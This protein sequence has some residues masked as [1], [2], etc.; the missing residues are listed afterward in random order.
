LTLDLKYTIKDI[1]TQSVN[2]NTHKVI[3]EGNLVVQSYGYMPLPHKL[4]A[5]FFN[6][7]A[8]SKLLTPPKINKRKPKANQ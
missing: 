2:T 7:N 3:K 6:C 5:H 4:N 1:R 8:L